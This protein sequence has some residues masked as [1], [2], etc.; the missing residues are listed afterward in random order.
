MALGVRRDRLL[1]SILF[2]G[3]L[4]TTNAAMSLFPRRGKDNQY[5]ISLEYGRTGEIGE[6]L[7]RRGSRRCNH[8]VLCEELRPR[9]PHEL[10]TTA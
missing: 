10:S 7:C 4:L 9:N 6:L 3:L 2:D 1:Q 5:R 8:Q